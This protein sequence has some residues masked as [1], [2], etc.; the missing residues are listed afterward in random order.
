MTLPLMCRCLVVAALCLPVRMHAFAQSGQEASLTGVIRDASGAVLPDVI[1]TVS[2]PQLIGSSRTAV[3]DARGS[4]YL[5]FLP[6]GSYAV[7]A[8][9]AGFKPSDSQVRLAPGVTL[10]IDVTLDIAPVGQ[11]VV[12]RGAAT[13]ID[14][15]ASSM[16]VLIDRELVENLP[17]S[18]TLSDIVNLAPGVVQY[19]ALGG[20]FAANAFTLDGA[21]GNEPGFGTPTMNPNINWADEVQVIAAGA[22]AQYGEFTGVKVNAITRSGSNRFSGLADYR[23]TRQS[24]ASDNRGSLPSNQQAR[25]TPGEIINR[26][27]GAFQLGGPVFKDRLWFFL[28][29]SAYRDADWPASFNGVRRTADSPS[30]DD[31]EGKFIAKLTSAVSPNIRADGYV[32]RVHHHEDGADAAPL[33][34]KDALHVYDQPETLWTVRLLWTLG[35][36]SFVEVRNGG[37]NFTTYNGP[38]V[39]RRTGPP[40]HYDQFT[41]VY[42]VNAWGVNTSESR[43]ITTSAQFTY[44]ATDPLGSSHE[45]KSGFEYEHASLRSF[46]G[47][48]GG[49]AFSDYD[50]QPYE[51]QFYGGSSYHPTQRRS[52]FYV[53]DS[54]SATKRLTVNA[55]IRTGF[56]HGSVPGREDAFSAHSISPR[57]GAAYD[58][59]GDHR[60]VVR[61]HYGRYHDA[62]VTSFFDFLDPLSQTPQITASVVGPGQYV[63]EYRSATGA[64]ATIDPNLRFPFSDEYVVGVERQLPWNLS[65]RV[66]VIARDFKDSVAFTDP[67]KIW[68]PVQRTDPGLDG[69]LGTADD[70]GPVTV[71]YSQDPSLSSP[72]LT[73]P[74]EAYRRYHGVQTIVSKRHAQRIEVQASYTWSRTIGSFNNAFAANAAN[75]DLGLPGVFS[76]PNG[77][78]NTDGRTPQDF[79][80]DAK[81]LGTYHFP[82]WGGFN[83]SGFYRYQSGRPWARS[84]F[85]GPQTEGMRVYVEPRGTRE[86]DAVNVLDLR[87]EKTWNLWSDRGRLGAFVDVFNVT[88]QGVAL[89]IANF[90]GPNFG[91]PNQWLDPRTVRAGVRVMF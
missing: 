21:S 47:L 62:M 13:T 43:P 23:T 8:E 88:N 89:R 90:S 38:P 42:S 66:Q 65:G 27:E 61:F 22:D 6:A 80:H 73:N 83:V 69:R 41:G 84:V 54:W 29:G 3:S 55:G 72:F 15:R 49:I 9:M 45:I 46:Y 24:W 12:V 58:L 17:L 19:V 26:W 37:N 30:F 59:T 39:E 71:Y 14:M 68:Y 20:T 63:E 32:S 11:S 28:G 53:Q 82:K 86:L 2:S 70:G 87:V 48:I 40:A 79:T 81:V 57:V 50:G 7:H 85:F 51:V 33:I 74:A 44:L 67:A 25:F 56:Y 78:I 4:Y 76:N 52:T 34:T 5:T 91:V 60:T 75:N 31:R 18:R 64:Q 16:P 1:V 10:T 35:S 77:R 36:R